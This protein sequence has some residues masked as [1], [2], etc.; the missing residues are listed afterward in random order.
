MADFQDIVNEIKETNKKLDKMGDQS[1]PSGAAATEEKRESERSQKNSEAY[2]KTIADAMGGAAGGDAKP[3]EEDKKTGG[4]FA[5]LGRAFGSL[6]SGVGRGVG[7]FMGGIA[8]ALPYAAAFPVVMT[9]L[10]AGIAGFLGAFAVISGGALWVVSQMMPGI[11]DGLKEFD[12]VDGKNL[13]RVGW[14]LSALGVGFAAMGAGTAIQGIG[15][16]VGGITDSIGGLFGIEP[17]GKRMID[18]LV[19][20][21]ELELNHVNIENNAK[22]MSAYGLAMAKGATADVLASLGGFVGAVFEGLTNLLGG[23]PLLDKLK[24]FGA[25][26]VNKANVINNAA[27]MEHYMLAM[28][29]GAGAQTAAALGAVAGFVTTA[30]DGLSKML[31]GK[32]FLETTL[33]GLK[34]M[35][36]AA[37]GIDPVKVALVATAMSSYT[38]AMALG[39]VGEGGKA[40]G[41][42]ANFVTTAVDGLTSLIGGGN[43]LETQLASL[44]VMSKAG[45]SG[46]INAENVA[47]VATAMGSYAKAMAAGAGGEAGLAIGSI[48]N[49]VGTAVDGLTSFIFGGEKK[50]GIDKMIDGLKQLSAVTGIDAANVENNAKAMASYA[51]AMALGAAAEGAGAL[52]NIA[53]FVGGVVSSISSFF[54]V[55]QKDPITELK[56]FAAIVITEPEVAQIEA[57]AKA[58]ESYA[59]AM[60]AVGKVEGISAWGEFDAL[61][62]GLVNN[63]SGWLG[64]KK[65]PGP[66]DKLKDFA[67][68]KITTEEVT[69]IN[70]NA[71]ALEAYATAMVTAQ[72]AAPVATVWDSLG[73]LAT[74]ILNNVGSWLGIEAD[75]KGPLDK[76]KAFAAIK[77]TP[78]EVTQIRSNAVALDAYKTAMVAANAVPIKP[79][80]WDSLGELFSGILGS[81]TSLFSSSDDPMTM[82]KSFASKGLTDAEVTQLTRNSDSFKLYAE[83]M[84]N[85]AAAG[86]AFEDAKVPN[87]EKF[88]KQLD[89][90]FPA[91]NS[92]MK[93]YGD[94]ALSENFQTG[95]QN[96]KAVFSAFEGM[97]I[98]GNQSQSIDR[99]GYR[100]VKG[101]WVKKAAGGSFSVGQPM[102][103]G[104]LG[105]EMII[106]SSSGR[107]LNAQR[108]AQMQQASLRNK[109]GSGGGQS[110]LNN[111]PVSNISTNQSN[112]TV[113]ATPLVHPSPIIGMVNAAA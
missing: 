88:A 83:A 72:S 13:E 78:E 93:N 40:I 48:A 86:A 82:M 109:M 16:L 41:A 18:N 30:F 29:R 56:K 75:K 46:E 1:D 27:A 11:A 4:I 45:G 52:K 106:P 54:G 35:S 44:K 33:D 6:G 15:N 59:G 113:A 5:G 37:G 104:E 38:K 63:I 55:E 89:A 23:V 25:E 102:I 20:F 76:L 3:S 94:P 21:G 66:M 8:K 70:A 58:L 24:L 73:T 110:V 105:P 51:K 9:A 112:T 17:G 28:V 85:I 79:G 42:I 10:G 96:L 100:Q 26:A 77:V 43:V 31:G 107:V 39:A 111:M 68:I 108:T 64:I 36:E 74:G 14:G 95:G 12:D 60:I 67:A 2:L 101:Q 80:V 65:E 87:L 62:G 50:T 98:G 19:A 32:S 22:A 34:K 99:E 69:Q 71:S 91:L 49:F 81:L 7:G 47:T 90:S 61:F 53:G 84:T 57:N 103:V 97:G 92:A